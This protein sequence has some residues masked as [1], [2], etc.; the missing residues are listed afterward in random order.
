[1]T[2]ISGR[3]K[4]TI[5]LSIIGHQKAAQLLRRLP[6]EVSNLLAARVAELP[7]PSSNQ[8]AFLLSELST[9]VLEAPK[10]VMSISSSQIKETP[11]DITESSQSIQ[12]GSSEERLLSLPP[13]KLVNRLKNEKFRI[14]RYILS[15][16]PE[17]KANDI[18]T[19]LDYNK[20]RAVTNFVIEQFEFSEEIKPVI[21]EAILSSNEAENG[22][23]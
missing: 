5:L 6:E 16:L 3:E 2:K 21:I 18:L 4:A 1:M 15:I 17:G 23:N 22:A 8:I 13:M 14:Q 20:K 10:D 7:K 19:I 11:A 12:I 9:N